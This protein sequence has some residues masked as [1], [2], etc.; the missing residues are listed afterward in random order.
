MSVC[1]AFQLCPYF[2]SATKNASCSNSDQR[3]SFEGHGAP[4]AG[5]Y[6]ASAWGCPG[7]AHAPS[8]AKPTSMPPPP[9]P[10]SIDSALAASVMSK[11]SLRR[12]S[13]LLQRGAGQSWGPL[14][15]D[16]TKTF[17]GPGLCQKAP[18]PSAEEA[19]NQV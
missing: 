5:A 10:P 6:G 3:P 19:G 4:A 8:G 9:P 15:W 11:P 16:Q 12:P 7:P 1:I 13:M 18:P 17:G 14:M 2:A